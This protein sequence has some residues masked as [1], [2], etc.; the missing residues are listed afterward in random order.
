VKKILPKL[1]IQAADPKSSSSNIELSSVEISGFLQ[2]QVFT[3]QNK[4]YE[5]S[6][7]YDSHTTKEMGGSDAIF[8]QLKDRIGIPDE[9]YDTIA[10]SASWMFM[11]E[12]RVFRYIGGLEP[13]L[14][15]EDPTLSPSSSK[16]QSS[17][18]GL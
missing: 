16:K 10:A 5:I 15:L 4:V 1:Q 18:D 12:H 6:V 2:V 8:N 17:S 7:I 9:S 13:C 3:F 14:F 11:K